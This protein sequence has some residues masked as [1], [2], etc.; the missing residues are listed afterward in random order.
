MQK[1]AVAEPAHVPPPPHSHYRWLRNG[2]EAVDAMLEAIGR[3]ERSVRLETFIF[4]SGEVGDAFRDALIAAQQRGVRVRVMCDALG[5]IRLSTSYWHE[6]VAAGGEFR[7]FNPLH[8]HR[9][10]YRDHRK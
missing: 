2:R 10:L 8:T 9:L 4:H 5:S 1:G 7:W 6:L 3:A